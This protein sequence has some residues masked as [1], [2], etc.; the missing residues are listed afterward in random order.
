MFRNVLATCK[1]EGL[2][3]QVKE[4]LR[5]VEV[6]LESLNTLENGGHAMQGSFAEVTFASYGNVK[7]S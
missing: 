6:K 4:E 1:I 2:R 7:H 3:L 5:T